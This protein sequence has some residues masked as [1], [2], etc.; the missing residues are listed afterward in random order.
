MTKKENAVYEVDSPRVRLPVAPSGAM[1]V[2]IFIVMQLA[3]L[4]W[5]FTPDLS[6]NG[7]D[8]C[9]YLLGKAL[10]DGKGYHKIQH[11]D[12][13]AETT[14]PILY[15]LMLAFVHFFSSSILLAKICQALLGALATLMAFYL[16][17]SY[18]KTLL[19]PLVALCAGCATLAQFSTDLM[20]E[21]PYLFF[22]LFALYLYDRSVSR[23][24]DRWLFWITIV[25]SVLPMHCR[26][27]GLAFSVSWVLVNLL[28]KR[29]RYMV[30]H[31]AVL[32]VTMVA[33]HFA[34]TGGGGYFIHIVL[35]NSYNPDA[36]FVT[37]GEMVQR[38]VQNI[39]AY[40]SSILLRSLIPLPPQTPE[41][42]RIIVTVVCLLGILAG[43]IRGLFGSMKFL[44]FY[45]FIY[46]GILLIWQTQWSSERFVAGV[47]PF[48]YFFLLSGIEAFLELVFSFPRMPFVQ[49]LKSLATDPAQTSGGRRAV[50]WAAAILVVIV[51]VSFQF[52]FARQA[53]QLGP[54]WNNFYSCADW[55]RRNTSADAV[56][57]SRK[58]ELF[59][60]RS[61][62]AGVMYPYS[63][64]A[65]KIMKVI[66][67]A[68]VQYIVFDNFFWTRTTREYLYPVLQTFR[69]RFQM[70]YALD[71][72][73]TAIYK[74]MK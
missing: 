7:D 45:V 9:F 31:A 55:I 14:T 34:T 16:F 67:S 22:S 70:V 30:A 3:L 6:T 37:P 5:Q 33:F 41:G 20:S 61:Q 44:S 52:S 71:N 11:P 21:I 64:D 36:G 42:L 49:R 66:D 57:M 72:P 2:R 28:T 8:A 38:I 24:K 74:V 58:V 32:A 40:G 54:D 47:I 4:A 18:S 10:H 68:K 46:F 53:K 59:Y 1:W 17:K 35:R 13:P 50:I 39:Q 26:S 48:L 60:V 43:W 29:Y 51:N 15:P 65:E 62:H 25:A 56:V 63:H 73:P 23:P 12:L 19:L 69:D 27:V